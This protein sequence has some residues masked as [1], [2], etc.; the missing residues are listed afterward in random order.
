MPHM[1]YSFTVSEVEP[2][3]PDV[4]HAL[5]IKLIRDQGGSVTVKVPEL[6]N[7]VASGKAGTAQWVIT[8][9]PGPGTD[10]GT[11]SVAKA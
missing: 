5:L 6:L 2:V 8:A 4:L 9:R 1:V 7:Q 11:W 10:E 3:H